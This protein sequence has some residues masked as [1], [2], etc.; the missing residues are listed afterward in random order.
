MRTIDVEV[1][2]WVAKKDNYVAGA[3]G[4]ANISK[5]RITFGED[6]DGYTKTL[7][8]FDAAGENPVNIIL[9]SDLLEDNG[10]STRV[11]LVKI[12]GEALAV[13]GRCS[14]V[15]N[16][17]TDGVVQRT[18]QEYLKVLHS[19][20][21][22]DAGEP[23][24][25]TPTQAEQLQKEIDGVKADMDALEESIENRLVLPGGEK[26]QVLQKASNA[27]GDVKWGDAF[28]EDEEMLALMIDSGLI[29]P[30]SGDGTNIYTNGDGSVLIY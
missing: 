13:E 27:D 19:D 30:V 9:T 18:V 1:S 15:I 8:W 26:G 29:A 23:E 6:W 7:T 5:L 14:F 20:A 2:G 10:E 12:P 25:P 22:E 3:R 4:E 17:Y 28:P 16:G 24:D 11:Y 21:A